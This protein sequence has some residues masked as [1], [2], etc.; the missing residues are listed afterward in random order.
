LQVTRLIDRIKATPRQATVFGDVWV[1]LTSGG[2]ASASDPND[3][4]DEAVAEMI[5]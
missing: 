3:E 4:R 2:G 5:F 1:K